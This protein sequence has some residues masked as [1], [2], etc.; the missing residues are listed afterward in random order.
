MIKSTDLRIGNKVKVFGKIYTIKELGEFEAAME[1]TH[2][3]FVYSDVQGVELTPELLI[4]CGFEK[5]T[6][7]KYGGW[8][9]PEL[10]DE[11]LRIRHD[12]FSFYHSVHETANPMRL[13][14]LHQ[15]QNWYFV[16]TSGTELSV[17]I[18]HV[19]V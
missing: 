13:E 16:M 18:E 11:R 14:H 9:S 5:D 19:N 7:G 10:H 3:V 8:L 1:E 17:S 15:L 4:T 12:E 6:T 2:G